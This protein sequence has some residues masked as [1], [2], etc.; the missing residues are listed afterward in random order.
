MDATVVEK[1]TKK[2]LGLSMML[3][4]FSVSNPKLLDQAE[5]STEIGSPKRKK[6]L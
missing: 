4:R 6:V 2:R 5:I 1:P 3:K